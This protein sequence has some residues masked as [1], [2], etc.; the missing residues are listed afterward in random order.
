MRTVAALV[1]LLGASPGYAAQPGKNKEAEETFAALEKRLPKVISKFV[2]D[3]EWFSFV[4]AAGIGGAVGARAEAV[5]KLMRM[6]GPTEGKVTVVI[7]L[8]GED[9]KKRVEA[10]VF[11]I[12]LRYFNGSWTSNRLD[13]S[14]PS[15]LGVA[16]KD[17]AETARKY[18]ER[19][20]R[21]A[22]LLMKA[23]DLE[24]E[25]RRG[26]R[27]EAE[28]E[29]ARQGELKQRAAKAAKA[30]A[31]LK[32]AAEEARK[33]RELW[34]KSPE[35]KAELKRQ[36]EEARKAALKQH[37]QDAAK[38]LR[39][40][41]FIFKNGTRERAAARLQQLIRDHPDTPSAVTARK[42]L[43]EWGY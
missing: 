14:W 9:E 30:A 21:G 37:E 12:Y 25:T 32:A 33:E 4:E 36:A 39:F 10:A 43:K 2:S 34:E 31:A 18:S 1:V 19:Y 24:P 11:S 23:I 27:E 29:A 20:L 8:R 26:E 38:E 40:A 41:Q 3:S 17:V 5:V 16:D 35:G 28:R 6:T 7:Y 13:G 42:L 22:H 15:A